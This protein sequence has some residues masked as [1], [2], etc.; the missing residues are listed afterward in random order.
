MGYFQD[1]YHN[2]TDFGTNCPKKDTTN[3]N[4]YAIITKTLIKAKLVFC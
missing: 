4:K 2:N 1:T 3:A